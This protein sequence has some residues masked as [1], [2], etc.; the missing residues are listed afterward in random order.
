MSKRKCEGGGLVGKYDFAQ[1]L[2]SIAPG[3]NTL[4]H[5]TVY[6]RDMEVD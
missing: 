1:I 4:C 5:P 6:V 3:N 2:L